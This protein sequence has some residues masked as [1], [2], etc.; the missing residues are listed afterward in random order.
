MNYQVSQ[1]NRSRVIVS[2][3]THAIMFMGLPIK[4]IR[5]SDGQVFPIIKVS[6]I[7]DVVHSAMFALSMSEEKILVRK[8]K[9]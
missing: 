9:N 8:M 3:V 4:L 5:K 6:Q 7:T 2:T 1:D